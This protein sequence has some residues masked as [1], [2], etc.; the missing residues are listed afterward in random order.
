[1]PTYL[2][3]ITRGLSSLVVLLL[4]AACGGGGGGG[5]TP[6][7]PSP[8]GPPFIAAELDSFPTGSVPTGFNRGASVAV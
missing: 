5:E 7:Q 6:P 1:M 3:G 8:T 4:L 2:L